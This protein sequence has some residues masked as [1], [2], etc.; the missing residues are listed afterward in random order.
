MNDFTQFVIEHG[1]P[2]LFGVVLVEQA[3][4]PLPAMPCLLAAGALAG[5]SESSTRSPPSLK[6]LTRDYELSQ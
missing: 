1:T 3:G 6:R 4:L 2:I 5:P